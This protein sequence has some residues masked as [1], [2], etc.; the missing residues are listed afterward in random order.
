MSFMPRGVGAFIIGD[1][2]TLGRRQDKHL[3]KLIEILAARGMTLAWATYLGDDRQ[4]LIDVFDHSFVSGDLVF[5]FGG[6]GVTPDD[7]TRQAVSHALG[8][9][10]LLHPEA[11]VLIRARMAQAGYEVT[12]ERL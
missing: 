7:H 5:S 11:E 2:I 6:I 4:R 1:E 8:R 3:G 12:P 9:P 10:L